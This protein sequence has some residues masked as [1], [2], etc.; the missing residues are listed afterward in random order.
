[1]TGRELIR[2]TIDVIPWRLRHHIRRLPVISAL[3]RR[4]VARVLSGDA[5]VHRINAGPARGARFMITLPDDKLLWTGTWESGFAQ[6][7]SGEVHAGD[8]C[9]DVGSHRGFLAAVM[10]VAG[11]SRVVCFEPD[12]RN[13]SRLVELQSLNEGFPLQIV[14]AAA[15]DRDGESEF[16]LMPE[17][18]MGRLADS[19]FEA[20]DADLASRCTV[21][22]VR[23]D[24]LVEN[25]T[26]PAPDVMK[27]DVEGAEML[28]LEGAAKT[29][30]SARPRL[31]IE[32]HSRALASDCTAF[33]ESRGYSIRRLKTDEGSDAG[34]DRD[35]CHIFAAPA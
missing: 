11:A 9:Y 22:I 30:A 1:M 29:I 27:I 26:A 18:T 31:F 17:L 32:A 15:G 24:T 13:Q 21:A 3:Q 33:L 23:I 14:A 2:R 7:M 28:V 35:I 6:A 5:F 16:V 10:S 4:F 12:P 34:R 19:G 20:G 25:G 8:V